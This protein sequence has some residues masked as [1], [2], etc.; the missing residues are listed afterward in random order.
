MKAIHINILAI[1]CFLLI[2][3]CGSK[4]GSE[5]LVEDEKAPV[6]AVEEIP[7][8]PRKEA[9]GV[10]NGINIV[11]DYGSPAVKGRKIWG[12]LEDYGKVWRAGAN[13]T[14]SVSFDKNALVNGESLEIGKYALFIIPGE[15]EWTVIFN[16]DWDEWGAFAYDEAKDVLRIKTKPIWAEEIRERLEYKISDSSLDFAW[17]KVRLSLDINQ[18]SQ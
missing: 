13:A 4:T 1:L 17:G 12:G 7:P 3:Q 18:D 5:T 11:V 14:T 15:D 16:K 6:D 2:S 10:A 9:I 8:S